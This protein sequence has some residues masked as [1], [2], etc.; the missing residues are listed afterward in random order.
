[1]AAYGWGTKASKSVIVEG[2]GHF[3]T[4]D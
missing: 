4:E 2:V 1:M 3:R